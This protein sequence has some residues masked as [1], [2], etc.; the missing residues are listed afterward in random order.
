MRKLN[1]LAIL[2]LL[3]GCKK[4]KVD[5]TPTSIIITNLTILSYPANAPGNV[6]WDL[7]TA[8]DIYFKIGNLVTKKIIYKSSTVA[9]IAVAQVYYP[10]VFITLDNALDQYQIDLYDD[11]QPFDD[12]DWMGGVGFKI[13]QSGNG[14]PNTVK[15]TFGNVSVQI[16]LEYRF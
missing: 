7:T 13:W 16:N 1:L 14:N 8:P 3:W 10:S 4:D 11:D 6:G 2:L 12:D 15:Y 5:P 9:N